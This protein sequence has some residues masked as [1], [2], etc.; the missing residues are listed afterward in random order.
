MKINRYIIRILSFILFFSLININ[1]T[2]GN[3]SENIKF[4]NITIKDGLSQSTV[5]TMYQDSKGYIW[6][7]TNDGLNRYNGNE[8]KIYKNDKYDKNSI[9]SNFIIDIKEDKNGDIWIS[10]LEGLSR[11]NTDSETIKNYTSDKDGGNLSNNGVLQ[12]LSTK[13]NRIIVA[14][15][16]GLNMY[17][18]N[19]DSFFRIL[20]KEGDLPSQYIYSVKEDSF[21]NIW[22]CTDAGVIE[23]D[24]NLKKLNSYEN[25]N[26][27]VEAYTT[28]DDLL[29][30]IWV[31]TLDSGLFRI[32]TR[33]QRV[34]NY[35]HIKGKQSILSDEVKDVVLGPKGKLWIATEG[36]LCNFDYEEEKFTAYKKDFFEED[37]IVNDKTRCLL[38]DSSGLIWVGAYSGISIFNPRNNFKHYRANPFDKNSLNGNMVNSIYREA[39]ETLW[40]GTNDGGINIIEGD[41]IKHLKKENSNINSNEVYEIIGFKDKIYVGTNEGLSVITK[42]D[43]GNYSITNYTVKD[44]LPANKVRSLIIDS[45]GNL[46]IG[47]VKGL[48]IFDTSSCR[49]IDKP[50]I[51][52]E[53]GVSDKFI[54]SLYEDSKGNLYIGCFLEGGLIKVNLDTKTHKIYKYNPKDNTS[55]SNNTILYINEDTDG[56]ILV[57]TNHGLNILNPDT[58]KFTHYTENDGLINNTVYGI[59]VDKNNY[60]WM[61]TNGGI[62]MFSMQDK[63]FRN[64]TVEDGLQSYEFNGGSCFN[65]E[66]GYLFFGG[67]NGFNI[68]NIDNIQISTFKPK[69]I[70]DGFEVNGISKKDINNMKFEFSENNIKINYFTNDYKNTKNTK[71]Y[72]RLKGLEEDW[73]ETR[74]NLLTF[75]KLSP[76]DYDLEIKTITQHGI[77]SEVSSV[78]FTIKPPILISKYALCLY[79]ILIIL[80]IYVARSKV[81]TLDSLVNIRTNELRKEMKRNEELFN[82]VLKLEKTKNNYFVNLS[83]E[84]RTPLNVITSISQLIRSF[85]KNDQIVPNEKLSYYMDAM[86]RNC[87]RLLSL[88]NNLIDYSKI[89][90]NS[91]VINKQSVDIVY[92]VE[93]TV[94]DMKD[95]IEDKGIELIFDTDVEEKSIECDKLDIE[96]CIINLVSNAGKFT[97][98]GGLI[99]VKV[100]D[101]DTEIKISVKDN[102][103]GISEENQKIIFDR[104]NQGIDKT[105]E[106]KGGSGL[107]LTITKQIINLHGGDIELKS[108][109]N[110]GSEFII[111]LPVK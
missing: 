41:T 57:G 7:G 35:R 42:S 110:V 53:I 59:L 69:V 88:I 33:N 92:L 27:K 64:F 96:R 9:I 43:N 100:F 18:K 38:K 83:H 67:I 109:L 70:F 78:K 40:I 12:V 95:Y 36:G 49:F 111:T 87:N 73:N 14:T 80:A 34:D 25:T 86:H 89:E 63:T 66:D 5:D 31:C 68:I 65:S 101:L 77:I 4:N 93:E 22:V 24:K 39:D 32:N 91:Y 54:R 76:G 11:I 50:E 46:L 51:F 28:Y 23:F 17:D 104:F 2:Y 10:T 72:Y 108:K 52:D 29:G 55:I 8:F 102:G 107:G 97:P 74:S 15:E 61:S 30:N 71:Y 47:T 84:L 79:F 75:A 37:S 105:S 98:E 99:E 56:N 103:A 81:K 20:D 60:V 13:D 19:K 16:D 82:Q 58:D 62:S 48:A 3:I 85:I 6:I 106:Q 44:G 45:K 94:L 90:N 26:R 1:I 21:G